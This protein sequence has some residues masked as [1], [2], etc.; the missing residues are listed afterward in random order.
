MVLCIIH[1]T[2]DRLT[3]SAVSEDYTFKSPD[4]HNYTI[5]VCRPV[6]T[7]TWAAKVDEPK[8]IGGFTRR[9]HGDFSLG[10]VRF[11]LSVYYSLHDVDMSTLP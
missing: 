6:I 11:I 4:G 5:N 9:E 7:E 8:N 2:I 1:R 3:A 10:C